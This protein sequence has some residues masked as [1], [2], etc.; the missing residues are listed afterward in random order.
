MILLVMSIAIVFDMTE[1]MDNFFEHQ[2]TWREI[3]MDYYI[4]F[5]PY[6]LNMFASLFIFI[7]VIVFTSKMA[8]DSEIIAILASGM[9]YRRLLLPYMTCA[10]IL[11]I[12][13]F[14]MAGY[15][16]PPASAKL[17]TFTDKYVEHFSHDNGRNVQL[18]VRPNETLYMESFQVRTQIGYRASIERF[19]GKTLCSRLTADRIRHIEGDRW[20]VENYTLREFDN[21]RETLSRG[22]DMDVTLPIEPAEL[23]YTAQYAEMMTNP[24]LNDYIDRQ[25]ARGAGNVL[26]FQ[27]QYHKR[28]AAAIGAFIMTLLGVTLSSKKV[29]G[30][31][32]KNLGVGIVLTAAYILFSTV[33]TTF[34]VNGV[35]SAFTAAWLPNFV[36][37]AIALYLYWR[38]SR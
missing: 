2:L 7:S 37:L 26:A 3:M 25:K 28:W 32:G 16:I 35:M 11:A 38:V 20:H 5:I 30:G 19:H 4:N 23:F 17:L 18:Q 6:Y 31:M 29:R 13:I 10:T 12:F 15:V 14:W 8:G 22:T 36:F 21:L 9:S 34:A 1:K 27:T 33:S 24:E